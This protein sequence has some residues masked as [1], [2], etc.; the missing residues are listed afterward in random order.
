MAGQS[1]SWDEV[2][3]RCDNVASSRIRAKETSG[4]SDPGPTIG[5][6]V[7]EELETTSESV[8]GAVQLDSSLRGAVYRD[9]SLLALAWEDPDATLPYDPRSFYTLVPEEL[10]VI[11]T[12]GRSGITLVP[13]SR[14]RQHGAGLV[15]GEVPV[16][17]QAPVL[18]ASAVSLASIQAPAV[19]IVN[20]FF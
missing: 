20:N 7:G 4:S 17:S 14:A 13:Q 15:E 18:M 6:S 12:N 2:E 3:V 10:E 19:S 5:K 16:I 9:S 1:V 8:R 11:E